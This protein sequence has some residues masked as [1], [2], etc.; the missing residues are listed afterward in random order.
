MI[1][2]ADLHAQTACIVT[3]R[4]RDDLIPLGN[5]HHAPSNTSTLRGAL[6]SGDV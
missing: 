2:P 6:T 3:D 4:D 1:H 5:V